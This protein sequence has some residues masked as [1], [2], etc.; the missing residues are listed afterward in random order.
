MGKLPRISH[1]RLPGRTEAAEG[2]T[3]RFTFLCLGYDGPLYYALFLGPSMLATFQYWSGLSPKA[4]VPENPKPHSS[5]A[6][7]L[8]PGDVCSALF[9]DQ[10]GR[11]D[12][13]IALVGESLEFAEPNSAD[14]DTLFRM[15][16]KMASPT[17]LLFGYAGKIAL[18]A[19]AKQPDQDWEL[20]RCHRF[21]L[22]YVEK[23]EYREDPQWRASFRTGASMSVFSLP[24]LAHQESVA[25][26][27]PDR[28]CLV[29]V[30]LTPR[31]GAYALRYKVVVGVVPVPESFEFSRARR[32]LPS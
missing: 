15:A 21:Q 23:P 13:T 3:E 28:N 16:W 27:G 10:P 31:F 1:F 17:N 6:R 29:A 14:A 24:M 26:D 8:L 11:R 4:P 12:G 7:Q 32:R 25:V 9:C 5:E 22:T 2:S 18:P 20:K 19:N 30:R